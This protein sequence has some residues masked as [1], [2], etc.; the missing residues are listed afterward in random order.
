MKK[1]NM[2]KFASIQAKI[3]HIKNKNLLLTV[4]PDS[5]DN[6]KMGLFFRK[7]LKKAG[8]K[9]NYN[10]KTRSLTIHEYGMQLYFKFSEDQDYVTVQRI[11]PDNYTYI[12]FSHSVQGMIDK[13]LEKKLIDKYLHKRLI[14]PIHII[15][16]ERKM[17]A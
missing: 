10:Q 2:N 3:L 7:V 5:V 8:I 16:E 4:K 11:P 6:S 12:I 14:V 1:H 15:S 13:L 17:S 9:Y